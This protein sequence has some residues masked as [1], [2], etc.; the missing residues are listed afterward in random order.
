MQEKEQP[1]R[2]VLDP[3]YNFH[4]GIKEMARKVHFMSYLY[5]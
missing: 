1:L 4:L 2:T 5:F 3:I